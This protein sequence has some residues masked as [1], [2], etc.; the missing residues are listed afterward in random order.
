MFSNCIVRLKIIAIVFIMRTHLTIGAK[1]QR[2]FFRSVFLFPFVRILNTFPLN[3]YLSRLCIYL[4]IYVI[5][6]L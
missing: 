1:V 5:V 3:F 2:S 4:I 6:L